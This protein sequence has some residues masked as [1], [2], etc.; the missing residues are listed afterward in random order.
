MNVLWSVLSLVTKLTLASPRS[1]PQTD[2]PFYILQVIACVTLTRL[3]TEC[4]LRANGPR[5]VLGGRRS[6]AVVFP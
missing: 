6:Y 5:N 3:W 4:Y 2:S 1:A